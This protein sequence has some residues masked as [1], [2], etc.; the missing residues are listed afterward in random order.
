MQVQMRHT[1]R[2]RME[3]GRNSVWA[4]LILWKFE[5]KLA[6]TFDDRFLIGGVI[7]NFL[8]RWHRS[9]RRTNR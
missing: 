2:R 8:A 4:S 9:S 3:T 7:P 1:K 6:F 5:E